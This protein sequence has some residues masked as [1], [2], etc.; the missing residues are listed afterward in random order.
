[1]KKR[2]VITGVL[3]LSLLGFSSAGMAGV[4]I[5]VN[6][7]LPSIGINIPPPPVFAFPAPPELAVIPGTY[8]YYCPDVDFNL[9]FYDGYWYRSDGGYW[10]SSVSY[11][12]PWTYIESAPPVLLSVPPDYR[13]IARGGRRI[14]Y[15]E[16]RGNWRAWQRDRYWDR[17]GWGRSE[18]EMHHGIAPYYGRGVERG[19]GVAPSYGYR[20]EESH[21][22]GAPY[23]SYRGGERRD[24]GRSN[25][26]GRHDQTG[27]GN[28]ERGGHERGER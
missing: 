19:H 5:G 4:H 15:A 21:R 1:M 9:F 3:L 7:P 8:V 23:G 11:D 12:G 14:P 27:R 10:Y 26:I 13:I 17:V 20:G 18:H 28:M 2:L 6:I 25:E 16:L 22:G 24:P